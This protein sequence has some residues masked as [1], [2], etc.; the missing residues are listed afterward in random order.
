MRVGQY[1]RCPIVLEE[2]DKYYP[3]SFVL[4]RI[5]SINELS[6]EITIKL[7]DLK[8]SKRFYEH[9]FK[10]VTFPISKVDR[11]GAAKDAPVNTS[12]GKGKIISKR[13][14]KSDDAFYEYF[15]TLNNGKIK[16]FMENL[17]EIDYSAADYQPLKQ[18][19]RY[20]FQN[21]TW[22]ANRLQ[23]SY[24][25]HMI[26]NTVY[27]FKELVGC[28]TFLMSHQISTIV[29]TFESRPIRY[30]LA[31]EVGL[32][33]TI[34]ACSIVKIM[35]S[36]NK[37]LRVLYIVPEMLIQQW[38]NELEYKFGIITVKSS[39]MTKKNANVII[40]LEKLDRYKN[41]LDLNWDIL[42]VDETHRLL[43]NP[44]KYEI[45]LNLSKRIENILLLSAT[46][47]QNRKSEYLRLLSLLQP[48]QYCSMNLDEFSFIVSKQKKIQRRVNGILS[49][50]NLYDDYKEDSLD[51][52]N[53]LAEELDDIN[54]KKIVDSINFDTEDKGIK[55]MQQ[56]LSY[57]S[58][59][60]RIERNIIRN[61]RE[62]VSE[63][64]GK[65]CL[66]EIPYEMGNSDDC[67]SEINVYYALLDFVCLAV[68]NKNMDIVS[69]FRMFQA[70]FS[71]PWALNDV[72]EELNI[73][74]DILSNNLK[75]WILQAENE[76]KELDYILDENPDKIK[77]RLL[78][79]LDFIEQEI[80]LTN[81][82]NGKVVVFSEFSQTLWKF[83]EL[84]NRRGIYSV[85]FTS[86][87]LKEE[88]ED[89]V[90]EFQNNEKC[91]VILCDAT[92]GEGRNFQ[93]AD[94]IIHIDL[95]WNINEI[96]Q[97]IGRLDRLG[98][99]AEHLKV[100]SVVVYTEN[101]IEN[102]LYKIW[103]EGI[104]IFEQSLS[105]LEIITGELNDIIKEAI[106]DDVYNGLEKSVKDIIDIAENTRD[107]VEEEQLYD[108]GSVVFRSLSNAVNNMLK[109][110]SGGENNIFES[111]MLGWAKQAGLGSNIIKEDIVQFSDKMF[112][113]RAAIQSMFVPPDWNL[114][115]NTAIVRKEG[116]ILG[117]FSRTTA[118]KHE[119][120]LF[121][122][123]GDPVFDSII[124]NSIDSGRGR[125]CAFSALAP[126]NYEGFVFAY[127]VE[128]KINHL[129]EKDVPIKLLSQFRMYLPM[130]QIFVFVPIGKCDEVED[131]RLIEFIFDKRNIINADHI[132]QRAA[133]KGGVSPV[134]LFMNEHPKEEWKIMVDKAK[135]D[136][137]EKAKKLVIEMSD[138][139]S[140][141]KEIDRIVSG[142]ES[143]YIYLG[144]DM[145]KIV[146]IKRKY[147]AVYKALSTPNLMIDSIGFMI[148]KR[149]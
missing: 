64:L 35:Q 142:Y 92:G 149:R 113:A 121:Y 50:M 109:T 115:Y 23:V 107:E 127:N 145:E 57:I 81:D 99:D 34:E 66:Y 5:I 9:A 143:E 98:R 13:I 53:D 14:E 1:V 90:Y 96:E 38:N 79:A 19:K 119:D 32:G 106:E 75:I 17:I 147:E 134:E 74:D 130:K 72:C 65:R 141:K 100:N 43:K 73:N 37:S 47:I 87:M 80:P 24:N 110:Y 56:A 45:V 2:N 89:S 112:S 91:R 15:V 55:E 20:E 29:R 6:E 148:L 21:P 62:F 137:R 86:N 124:G 131:K 76:I 59:N 83:G 118:I 40:P 104:N 61:R 136:S 78:Y 133:K 94:W 10:S 33:K 95:P 85:C 26:N 103:N 125:C 146:E 77:G 54:L 129:I 97:R 116:K 39:L 27:G 30:M 101:T 22:Y 4:G 84:L 36:E 46:P 120:L 108:S 58:E 123:P 71:S 44:E 63:T 140:A 128:P 122:A 49:H 31:D 88:L 60:Y 48:E 28:R 7:F 51:K 52:L 18:M 11:C 114:Y 144:K 102:Q 70:M 3:R 135:K 67:Y 111:S 41:V 126:F 93:N 132:G 117:T 105:G 12:E 138:I 16:S 82:N 25:M 42:I 69:I 8:N 68:Q 139:D